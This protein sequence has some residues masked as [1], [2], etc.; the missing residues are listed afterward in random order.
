MVPRWP[1][2]PERTQ[3]A[4]GRVHSTHH[5]S[6]VQF[7]RSCV[8]GIPRRLDMGGGAVRETADQSTQ[9]A[10]STGA[11]I[12]AL[13]TRLGLSQIEL[14]AL[15]GVSNVTVNRWEHDRVRPER[16]TLDR[17]LRAEHEGIGTLA[18]LAN[19]IPAAP[20][21]AVASNLP[22]FL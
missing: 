5:N 8:G 9:A 17:L 2:I 20:R 13:R 1:A 16:D 22:T 14:A 21:R 18:G 12:R 6:D 3:V 11:R 7:L 10:T 19:S 15:L 4:P